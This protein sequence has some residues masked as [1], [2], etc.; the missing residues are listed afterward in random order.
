MK[1]VQCLC[2]KVIDI[3][4]TFL[5]IPSS[6]SSF[7]SSQFLTLFS[8]PLSLSIST[9]ISPNSTD[10]VFF[11]TCLHLLSLLNLWRARSQSFF[12]CWVSCWYCFFLLS[13]SW[14]PQ[15]LLQQSLQWQWFL[16]WKRRPSLH[17]LLHPYHHHL[18]RGQ[19]ALGTPDHPPS[20]KQNIHLNN[21]V[22]SVYAWRKSFFF[23][24][25]HENVT[26]SF[27]P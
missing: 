21:L 6:Y 11:P 22:H 20:S 13:F 14:C 10:G 24:Y 27:V 1:R 15:T 18:Q 5:L 4:P 17:P 12:V 7:H 8:S 9:T 19:G 25:T 2:V 3:L 26:L 16:L 23:I